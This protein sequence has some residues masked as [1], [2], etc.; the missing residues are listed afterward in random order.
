M[1]GAVTE[2][3]GVICLDLKSDYEEATRTDCVTMYTLGGGS[4]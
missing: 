2:R 1:V 4:V 3:G